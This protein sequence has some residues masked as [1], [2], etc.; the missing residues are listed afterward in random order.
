MGALYQVIHSQTESTFCRILQSQAMQTFETM[1]YS[2]LFWIFFSLRFKFVG[3]DSNTSLITGTIVAWTSHILPTSIQRSEYF[4]TMP[5]SLTLWSP[6]TATSIRRCFLI[7]FSTTWQY[8]GLNDLVFLDVE[9]TQNLDLVVLNH[10]FLAC[11]GTISK[12]L[13]LLLL[14]LINCIQN[15]REKVYQNHNIKDNLITW[16]DR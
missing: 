6:G 5:I 15:I 16:C 7:S 10:L 12:S 1:G 14:C 13:S 3:I 11:G 2:V 9:I 4:L 8:D